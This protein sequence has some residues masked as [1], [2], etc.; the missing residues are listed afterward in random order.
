[1][2]VNIL[3]EKKERERERKKVEKTTLGILADVEVEGPVTRT[4]A[5]SVPIWRAF[6]AVSRVREIPRVRG[7]VC[8]HPFVAR[9]SHSWSPFLPLLPD[10]SEYGCLFTQQGV[11]EV[12]SLDIFPQDAFLEARGAAVLHQ[13][14]GCSL[15]C[16]VSAR[17]D[18][19]IVA[20]GHLVLCYS[21]RLDLLQVGS[22]LQMRTVWQVVHRTSLVSK[23]QSALQT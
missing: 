7:A 9:Q 1:M 3:Q 21:L 2:T 17:S 13:D 16:L 6:T 15:H 10:L 22:S 18:I 5:C 4:I 12:L 11:V 20:K 19:F 14:P 23:V 8:S